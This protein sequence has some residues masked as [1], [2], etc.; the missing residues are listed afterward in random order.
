[1]EKIPCSVGILTYNSAKTLE[2]ALLSVQDFSDIIISDGGSTDETLMI[3]KRFGCRVIDQIAKHHPGP[4][5]RHP[6]TDFSA[7]H[8]QLL[9]AAKEDWYLRIDSDEY[10][11]DDLQ[12]EIRTI[13]QEDAYDG[14]KLEM[15]LQSP[16]GS[17][18]YYI[19]KPVFQV[20]LVKRA[21]GRFKR[22]VHEH[23]AFDEKPRLV[24]LKGAWN[25]PISKPDFETYKWAVNYRLTMFH[26]TN[27]PK[28]ISE[29]F[30]RAWYKTIKRAIG[31][32]IRVCYAYLTIPR[33]R[34][35]PFYYFRNRLYSQ[36][37]TFK[38]VHMIYFN[39]KNYA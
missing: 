10:L 27:P 15:H 5:P 20:R 2:R 29:Y 28:T 32:I 33:K 30:R 35:P 13:V 16:D 1:M 34:V 19:P 22:P 14:A 18:T 6:I 37:V 26:R 11:G 12:G 9:E 23:F 21:K 17:V 3:A 39:R 4:E 24:T 36:W 38:V 31:I 7:E 25:V 8:N